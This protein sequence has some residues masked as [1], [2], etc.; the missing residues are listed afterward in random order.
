MEDFELKYRIAGKAFPPQPIRMKIPGW[1]GDE[2]K[3]V[4]GSEPQLWHCPPFVEASTYGL[5]LTYPYETEC[6]VV[7]DNGDIRFEWDFAKEPGGMLTGNEFGAFFPR[8]A[9]YYL[10]T[11]N[12]DLQAPPGYV[13]RTNPHPRFFTDDTGTVPLA[14]MGHIRTEWWPKVL[15]VVFRVPPPGQR[16]I[17]RK[18]EAYV[19]LLA[20]PHGA[21]Y[22]ATRMTPAEDARRNEMEAQIGMAG[23]YIAGNV[24]HNPSGQ[25]FK[26]HYR[27]MG[28][29]FAREGLEGV[30]KVIDEAVARREATLAPGKTVA[31][32]MQSAI[33]HH[34][35]GRFIEARDL[36]FFILNLDPNNA[37]AADR[38]GALA[39]EHNL[40]DLEI[41]MTSRAVELNPRAVAY[42]A[43]LGRVLLERGHFVEAEG[44]L[45]AALELS[46]QD[47]QIM[48][49][50]ALATARRG[51]IGEA[52][53]VCRAAIALA[54]KQPMVHYR[55]GQILAGEN[56]HAD[57][58]AAY[59][60][61]LNADPNFAPAQT[62][63]NEI[64]EAKPA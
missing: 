55:L 34:K 33:D 43:H 63:L 59:K 45:R 60:A 22:K 2:V 47:P 3:K 5:E 42:R 7:N 32:Y 29:A 17:F 49:D 35:A 12:I 20:V 9:K 51:N 41:K 25:E 36:Y 23:A 52:I 44:V 30:E 6:Q 19:Q 31:Q 61:A 15:F 62:A 18:G 58:Q 39:G 46:P 8:P 38:L 48:A 57:A 50:F 56:L 53:L 1:A 26:D 54:P 28:R 11:T 10:F 16:H 4:N 27:V 14:M 13:I 21:D 24:W 64:S 40:P 37:E